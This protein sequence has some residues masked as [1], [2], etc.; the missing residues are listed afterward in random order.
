MF[1]LIR[2]YA[3][4]A[5]TQG[6]PKT[7]A[8][9][10]TAFRYFHFCPP[11]RREESGADSREFG[12]GDFQRSRVRRAVKHQTWHG[13]EVPVPAR[14]GRSLKSP[15]RT[16]PRSACHNASLTAAQNALKVRPGKRLRA[17]S[18][19]NEHSPIHRNCQL[20]A[21]QLGGHPRG[22]RAHPPEDPP[23]P[24]PD[25]RILEC[26]NRGAALLQVRKPA[27]DRLVQDSRGVKC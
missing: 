11:P 14:S 19:P 26:Y 20:P 3:Q 1:G 5:E 17:Q 16:N 6:R 2:G 8:C 13:Q 9:Q 21:T 10:F 4:G 27:E 12:G 7:E 25:V 24:R 23:S 15:A 22:A 18:G